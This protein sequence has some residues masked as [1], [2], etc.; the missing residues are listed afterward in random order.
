MYQLPNTVAL[1]LPWKFDA[2]SP[3]QEISSVYKTRMFIIV[4]TKARHWALYWA[5]GI[6]STPPHSTY[7]NSFNVILPSSLRLPS[8][9]FPW[10]FETKILY[11]GLFI[12]S[13]VCNT[14]RTPRLY[15]LQMLFN[16]E[17]D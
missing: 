12:F 13:Y 14:P 9:V 8:G 17:V 11:V 16:V 10:G 15:Q 4:L 2:Y 5:N 1:Y 7:R 6:E 3:V